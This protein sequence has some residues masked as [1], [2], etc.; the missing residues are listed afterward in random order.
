MDFTSSPVILTTLHTRGFYIGLCETPS[1]W[2]RT[3]RSERPTTWR[4]E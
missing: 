1:A 4:R 3:G 2:P